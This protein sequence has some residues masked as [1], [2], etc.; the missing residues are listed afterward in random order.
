[1]NAKL[2]TRV[3]PVAVFDVGRVSSSA[4]HLEPFIIRGL[5]EHWPAYHWTNELIRHKYG[6][7]RCNITLDSRPIYL[8][9]SDTKRLDDYMDR[10]DASDADGF[11]V[12]GYLF[13]TLKLDSEATAAN[14]RAILS[15]ICLPSDVFDNDSVKLVRVYAGPSSTGTLPHIHDGACNALLRGRKRWVLFS[16]P[17]PAQHAKLE[18]EIY[19]KWG[20]GTHSRDWFEQEYLQL[21]N[22]NRLNIWECVQE[23]GE[24]IYVPQNMYHVALNLT[25]V[26]GVVAEF[27][28]SG[29]KPAI[30]N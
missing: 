9:F 30:A 1:M 22:D 26:V 24:L 23:A 29:F 16:S 25:P 27:Q 17:D 18:K 14:G 12:D 3:S 4:S 20:E 7:I 19:A 21:Q 13:H 10:L 15:D 28:G 8:Q 6:Q 11:Q 2:P 5:V